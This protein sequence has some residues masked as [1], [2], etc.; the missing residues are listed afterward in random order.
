MIC[1]EPSCCIVKEARE[2]SLLNPNWQSNEFVFKP[3]EQEQG[4]RFR[5]I[6]RKMQHATVAPI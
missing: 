6:I 2:L 1:R 5:K 4:Q 3:S